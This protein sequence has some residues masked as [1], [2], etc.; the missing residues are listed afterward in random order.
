MEGSIEMRREARIWQLLERRELV[1]EVGTITI[2]EAEEVVVVDREVGEVDS[3][4]DEADR[5]AGLRTEA[6]GVD[7]G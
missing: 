7:Q 2:E 4:V 6:A 5:K 3:E 1:W